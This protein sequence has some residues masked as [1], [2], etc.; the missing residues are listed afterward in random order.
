MTQLEI[1]ERAKMYLEKLSQGINPL[2]DSLIAAEDLLHNPRI[3]KCLSFTADVL[4][5]ILRN[6]GIT[7]MEKLEKA[8]LFI[9]PEILRQYPFSDYPI[10]ISEVVRRINSLINV[11]RMVPLR[12]TIVSQFLEEQGLLM[13][14][15]L[16]DG[17]KARRPTELGLSMG[18]IA[19]ERGE[20]SH[21][22]VAVQ[23]DR[24]AQEYILEHFEEIQ[25][26]SNQIHAPRK[27]I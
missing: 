3:S 18:I 6:G 10:S 23:F 25:R 19:A 1:I 27:Q 21:S 14:A 12:Y 5:D 13:L 4:E 20:G 16:P 8:P 2:D 15:V 26:R 22:Y 7:P 9:P 11:V 17:K 24:R